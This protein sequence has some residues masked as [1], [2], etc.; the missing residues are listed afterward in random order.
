[1]VAHFWGRHS[2]RRRLCH[3]CVVAGQVG[4]GVT[5]PS[6]FAAL[7]V[8]T[9]ALAAFAVDVAPQLSLVGLGV[10]CLAS[11]DAQPHC[12]RANGHR[13]HSPERRLRPQL[14]ASPWILEVSGRYGFSSRLERGRR[15]PGRLFAYSRYPSRTCA[16]A[17]THDTC[18]RM[19]RCAHVHL[20]HMGTVTA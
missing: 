20:M 6:A 12:G 8:T 16:R 2:C 10:R 17:H 4:C 13:F 3:Y 18:T 11:H 9:A 1:M 15:G 14:P 19:Y 5:L 7:A